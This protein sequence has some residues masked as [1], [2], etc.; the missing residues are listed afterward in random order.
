MAVPAE[1]WRTRSRF[2]GIQEPSTQIIVTGGSRGIGESIARTFAA[3]G[4]KVVVASRKL[5]GV[6]AVAASIGEHAFAVAAHTGRQAD[7]IGLVQKTIERFGRV[8]VLVNNAGTNPYFGPMLGTE[9]GAWQKTFEINLQGYFWMAREVARHLQE[10]EAPGAIVNIASVAG[11]IA[12]PFQGV[13]AMTKAG[14][15]SM[16]KTLAFELAGS[17]IRVNAIAP[18]FV[19]TRLA[20]FIVQNDSMIEEI[21]RRTPLGRVAQPDE[22]AGGA[23]YLASDA[24]SYMTGQTLVIDGGMTV[25]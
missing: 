3:H 16:T 18:G 13:Y 10:R 6:Q 22:I 23:L 7:C 9:E 20:S 8:D 25:S 11:L 19:D 4:A 15:I 2:Q 5:E 21:L 12:A 14:V 17:R 1:I 24:S